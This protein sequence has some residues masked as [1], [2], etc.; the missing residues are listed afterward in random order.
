MEMH[1]DN[2]D[3]ECEYSID[4]L[5]ANLKDALTLQEKRIFFLEL[6]GIILAD[7]VYDGTER[8]MSNKLSEIFE[9]DEKG[10]NEAFQIIQDMKDVYERCAKYIK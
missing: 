4:E 10:V 2:N 3:F 5:L 9:I 1:I 8:D 6:V 7:G